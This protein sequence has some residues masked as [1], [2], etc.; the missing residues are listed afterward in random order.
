KSR[1]AI[2]LEK[3]RELERWPERVYDV[4]RDSMRVQCS[5]NVC[6]VRGIMAWQ[7]RN[8]HRA[9]MASGISKFDYEVTPSG[10]GFRILSES[11]S[12]V[13]RYQQ[14]DGRNHS[15]RTKVTAYQQ[16]CER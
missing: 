7:T 5:R 11:G 13:K 10:D 15:R 1:H 4:Q 14:A 2:F 3:R 9:T 16:R 8:G 6:K 12:V